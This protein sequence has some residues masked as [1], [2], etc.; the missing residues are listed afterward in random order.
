MGPVRALR[1]VNQKRLK[2]ELREAEMAASMRSGSR[3][4]NAR[5]HLESLSR[6]VAHSETL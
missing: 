2:Q 5:K 4:F 3:G 6:D 1:E